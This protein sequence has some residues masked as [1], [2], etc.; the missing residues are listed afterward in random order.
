MSFITLVSVTC[1]HTWLDI[2]GHSQRCD[3]I[4]LDSDDADQAMDRLKAQ[5]WITTRKGEFCPKHREAHE[6]ER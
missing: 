5:G 6:H 2:E 4:I 3:E 1:D